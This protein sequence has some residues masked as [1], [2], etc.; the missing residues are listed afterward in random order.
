[1][2]RLSA[3]LVGRRYGSGGKIELDQLRQ[4]NYHSAADLRRSD[5]SGEA[6]PER[7]YGHPR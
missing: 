4:D 2:S 3:R 5:N 7:R 1:M 6:I